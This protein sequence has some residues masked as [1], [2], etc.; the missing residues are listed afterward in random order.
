M[1]EP[2]APKRYFCE[3]PWTGLFSVRTNL[4]VT[5]CPCYLK[6]RIGNLNDN[7][8]HEI[9]NAD[10]LVRLRESFER[11]ELPDPCR[12]QLCPVAVGH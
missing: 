2:V 11:G 9:W 10:P 3:E 5:F 7:S 6:L 1:S 8:L 4:D 12:G